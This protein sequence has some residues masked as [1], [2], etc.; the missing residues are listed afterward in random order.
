MWEA[1]IDWDE[2]LPES[3]RQDW[4]NSRS[5][6]P[7]L[8]KK[9][10]PCCYHPQNAEVAKIKLHSFSDASEDAYAAAVYIRVEDKCGTVHTSLVI[11]KTK[12][13]PI[14]RLTIPRLEL[15]GA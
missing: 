15:C 14:K 13:A 3:I 1:R 2:L 9:H 5:E 6:L 7:L 8:T 11:A 10:I 4:M 12:V